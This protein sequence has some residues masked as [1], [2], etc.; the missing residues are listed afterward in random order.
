MRVTQQALG[1][2]ACRLG[3]P[4]EGHDTVIRQR[5]NSQYSKKIAIC[6]CNLPV[7]RF[8]RTDDKRPICNMRKPEIVLESRTIEPPRAP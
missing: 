4:C 1:V 7:T 6:M 3:V 5:F 2:Y 8:A